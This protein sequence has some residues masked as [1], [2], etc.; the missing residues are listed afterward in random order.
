MIS[1]IP[2][3]LLATVSFGA[4]VQQ[5][6]RYLRYLLVIIHPSS[7]LYCL[8]AVPSELN[9]YSEGWVSFVIGVTI[10]TTSIL[11]TESHKILISAGDL[12]SRLRETFW[13]WSNCGRIPYTFRSI[14]TTRGDKTNCRV[15]FGVKKLSHVIL[16]QLADF[17][18]NLLV[19]E[20]L[21]GL[22]LTI[23]DFAPAKQGFYPS[24]NYHDLCLR[25]AMS[26]HWIWQTYAFL[27]SAHELSSVIF[28]SLLGWDRPSEWPPLFGNVAEAYSL[29]RFWGVFWHRILVAPFAAFMPSF[30]CD[31][32][33]KPRQDAGWRKRTRDSLRALWIFVFS[34]GYHTL[35]DFGVLR[36]GTAGPE[37]RFFLLNYVLC[38]AETVVTSI[39]G[40][41]SPQA[42]ASKVCLRILGYVWVF[43]FFFCTT[44]PWKYPVVYDIA[45]REYGRQA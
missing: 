6:P 11:F 27:T 38:L 39:V 33:G 21:R 37:F 7:V 2:W 40:S 1:S 25:T 9:P 20:V 45:I 28:V 29:R 15:S 17:S 30:L 34:A 41:R 13:I 24:L 44:P 42:V 4:S 18:V 35:V 23:E 12:E 14:S 36:M 19:H 8:R 10:H 26:V 3:F 32:G 31:T 22:G 16:L 5:V 43:A